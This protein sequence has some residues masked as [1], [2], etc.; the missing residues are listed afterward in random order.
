MHT[1]L[2]ERSAPLL[3]EPS[4]AQRQWTTSVVTLAK[5]G[6]QAGE[7][8]VVGE[9]ERL[10]GAEPGHLLTLSR[11]W[12]RIGVRT[13]KEVAKIEVEM[14]SRLV[15]IDV[16]EPRSGVEM[17]NDEPGLLLDLA[18]HCLCW[19]LAAVDVAAWL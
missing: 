15:N 18:Q 4:D 14:A 5:G 8:L 2:S 13:E 9:A 17:V 11:R 10:G 6:E 7:P 1:T 12:G 3:I 16:C 19:R